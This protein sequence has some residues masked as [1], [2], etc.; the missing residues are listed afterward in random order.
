MVDFSTISYVHVIGAGGIGLSAVAKLLQHE[1]KTVTGSDSRATGVTEELVV[2][3]IP[4]VIGQIAKN[5][6]AQCDVVI[7]SGA[8][9]PSNPEREEVQRRGIP[10]LSYFDFIGEFSRTK[11]TIAVS[12]TNGKSSTTAMLGL[13][14]ADSGLDP[15]VIVGSMVPGF[16]DGNLHRGK[17]DL[18]V[19]EACEHEA[20][21]LKIDAQTIVLTNIEE[22]HLDF[23]RDLAHITETF[24]KFV[25]SLPED[26]LLVLN[27]DDHVSRHDLTPH[28]RTVTYAQESR[29]D[30]EASASQIGDGV[31]TFTVTKGKD[32]FGEFGLHVPGAFNVANAMAAATAAMELGVSPDSVR[33]TLSKYHGIWRRF[34]KVGEINGATVI[35]D[36]GHHPTAIAATVRA[37]RE[38]FP[39]RRIVLAFQ[40]HQHNRTKSLFDGFVASFDAADALVILEIFDV[41]GRKEEAD[42]RISARDLVDAVKRRDHERGIERDVRFIGSVGESEVVLRGLVMP[43][44][45]VL[46]MGA[47]DI[48]LIADRVKAG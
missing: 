16:S 33:E 40:P 36:Y 32:A 37:T 27:V 39:G 11:R 7:Y 2:M 8:V 34:E 21:M 20:N 28:V 1:G 5:V 3:G 46:L 22:D 42:A 26:G 10:Q 31:Q 47:G 6:P 48:Y 25:D 15:T 19:V 30:Y 29:A 35:S 45:V 12:G 13:M 44:D 17:S 4:V 9:P 14:L 38:F 41:A 23:Y 18:F 43:E 24:Q